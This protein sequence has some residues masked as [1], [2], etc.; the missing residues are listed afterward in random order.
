MKS[1]IATPIRRFSAIVTAWSRLM[2][3]SR[4]V[5]VSLV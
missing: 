2:P 5:N 1:C 3:G 4:I